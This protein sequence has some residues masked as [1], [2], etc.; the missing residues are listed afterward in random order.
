MAVNEGRFLLLI[1]PHH[2]ITLFLL[3]VSG[4][5]LL[6]RKYAGRPDWEA[7]Q[8]KTSKFV[9]GFPKKPEAALYHFR[10]RIMID[11]RRLV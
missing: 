9:P 8:A 10:F 2:L 1:S 3:Y 6:E 7:Y 5:P 11:D 4:V